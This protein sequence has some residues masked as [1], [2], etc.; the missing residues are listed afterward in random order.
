M[1]YYVYKLIDPRDDKIFYIGKG[2]G[3][4]MYNHVSNVKR[5]RIL[6]KKLHSKIK[7]ILESGNRVKYIKVFLTDCESDAYSKE[8]KLISEIGLDN[9]C[10]VTDGGE[11]SRYWSGKSRSE[12]TK[13]KISNSLRGRK[14]S[15]EVKDK[16]SAS[17]VGRKL[18]EEHKE[19][20]AECN[21][22]N[23]NPRY[24][25][26]HTKETKQKMSESMKGDKNPF[27]GKRHTKEAKQKISI[28]VRRSK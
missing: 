26:R 20:L 15:Q 2:T 1:K 9:L 10:N 7:K 16:I 19:K 28:G 6:N 17:L 11:E 13:R 21:I 5:D 24:G 4:R 23:K 25:K 22:G 27:F 12:E 18:S 14:M 3:L 8:K